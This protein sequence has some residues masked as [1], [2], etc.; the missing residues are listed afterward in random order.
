MAD[1][2]VNAEINPNLTPVVFYLDATIC[3]KGG[4]VNSLVGSNM[5]NECPLAN[6][7]KRLLC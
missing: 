2:K 6:P 4:Q 5:N 3:Q 1:V 7:G